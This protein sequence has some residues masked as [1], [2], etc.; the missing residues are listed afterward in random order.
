MLVELDLYKFPKT[1]KIMTGKKDEISFL[2]QQQEQIPEQK[3]RDEAILITQA[4]H[5]YF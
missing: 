3:L 5:Y 1:T 4:V 2:I